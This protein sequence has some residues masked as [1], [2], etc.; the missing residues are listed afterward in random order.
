M[1][2]AILYDTLEDNKVRCNV[3]NHHCTIFPS[4]RGVCGVRENRNGTLY[5]LVYGKVISEAVD[6]IE[7]K[8]FFHFLP[9]TKSL[10]IATVGC[11]FRCANCQN[12]Q[13]SQASKQ[14]G[15]TDLSI[16]G[17]ERTPEQ[18]IADAI[19]TR[20]DSISYTYTEPT[21][22]LEYALD[23]M[24][25]ARERGIKNCWVSNGYMSGQTLELIL[26]YL[27]AI[28]VDLKFFDATQYQKVCGGK[29]E[30][31]LQNL[32]TLKQNSVWVEVTTLSIPTLSDTD[33]LF[34]DI[35]RFI[36]TQL[37]AST[38]WHVSAF[39]PE[40]SFRLQ[41]LPATDV[42]TLE[43]AYEI[44]KQA[45]LQYVYIGNV[46]GHRG[47]HTYCPKCGTIVIERKGF[48]TA[49]RDRDGTCPSCGTTIDLTQ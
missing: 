32:K 37:G 39:S 36:Y 25:L 33:A 6:P 22:F 26:P 7:K 29:L 48:R 20:C 42:R 47:E 31:I 8:P 3:C 12:W 44:G 43:R 16:S 2:Q 4:T 15:Y 28:N 18:I 23:C 38:P 1:K 49:R 45:G 9:G 41:H 27:D 35:A 14:S 17:T 13:I 11:N 46:P 19:E 21:I 34:G 30:P 24:K 40:I 5:L 10:S